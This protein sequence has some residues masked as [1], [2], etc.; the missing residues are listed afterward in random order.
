ML[1]KRVKSILQISS[2]DMQNDDL[3]FS[4]TCH[5]RIV[6]V[7]STEKREKEERQFEKINEVWHR[8]CYYAAWWGSHPK[9]YARRPHWRGLKNPLP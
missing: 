6:T 4:S 2:K 3:L 9:Q 7:K 8:I 5:G 1:V